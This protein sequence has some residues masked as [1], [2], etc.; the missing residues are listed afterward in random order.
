MWSVH[1]G[2]RVSGLGRWSSELRK[3][4]LVLSPNL[5]RVWRWYEL[6]IEIRGEDEFG[7]VKLSNIGDTIGLGTSGLFSKGMLHACTG[8][9]R[10]CIWGDC[11]RCHC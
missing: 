1:L 10:C 5:W 7:G 11:G 9:L 4:V 2:R 8:K 3:D 6:R